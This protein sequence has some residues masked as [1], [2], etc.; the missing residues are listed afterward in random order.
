MTAAK[1]PEPQDVAALEGSGLRKMLSQEQVLA[2]VPISPLTLWRMEKK[3][4]FPKGTFI[5]ANKKIWYLDEI[6]RR[7]GEVNGRGRG[8]RQHPTPSKS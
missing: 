6:V 1:R 7:Q 8:R 4:T 5:S 2:I 3:G